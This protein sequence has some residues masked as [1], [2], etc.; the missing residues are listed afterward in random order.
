[1]QFKLKTPFNY[2][3]KFSS[4]RVRK[5]RAERNSPQLFTCRLLWGASFHQS[6]ALGLTPWLGQSCWGI[7]GFKIDLTGII[8]PVSEPKNTNF[9]Y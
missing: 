8:A 6:P 9:G 2:T 1:M 3:H 7:F 4:Q 5:S